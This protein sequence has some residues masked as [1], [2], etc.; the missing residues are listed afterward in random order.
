M[1]ERG[2]ISIVKM[3]DG[4]AGMHAILERGWRSEVDKKLLL[5]SPDSYPCGK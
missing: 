4:T 5:G 3:A 1:K 2:R